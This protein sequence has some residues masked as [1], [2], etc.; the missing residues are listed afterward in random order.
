[1]GTET[2]LLRVTEVARLLGVSHPKV[3]ELIAD[4]RLRSVR[5]DGCRRIRTDDL[6]NY[7]DSLGIT[8]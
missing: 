3:Y 5:L 1:M 8:C 6:R 2:L 4:G 7:V